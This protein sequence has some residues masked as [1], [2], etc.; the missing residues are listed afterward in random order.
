[1]RT[2][3]ELTFEFITLNSR[4]FDMKYNKFIDFESVKW[5]RKYCTMNEFEY[6]RTKKQ[7]MVCDFGSIFL[8]GFF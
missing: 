5:D 7:V 6:T 1:M 3:H 2:E 8:S 4:P